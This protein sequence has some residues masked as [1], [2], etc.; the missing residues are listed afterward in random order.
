MFK[1]AG[2]PIDCVHI[3]SSTGGES[4]LKEIAERTGGVFMK[5]TDVGNFAKNFKYLTPGYYGQLTS[6]AISAAALGATEIKK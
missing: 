1:E 2:V 6:G 5:F 3:G 4:T